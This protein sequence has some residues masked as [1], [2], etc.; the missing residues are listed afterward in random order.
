[1][2]KIVLPV[3]IVLSACAAVIPEPDPLPPAEN[4]TCNA[5]TYANLIGQDDEALER[6]LLMGLVRVIRP[7]MA[8]SM[9]YR[10]NRINFAIGASGRIDRIY[11]G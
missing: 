4:D 3:F 11:C 5:A 9:D 6:V 8:V 7:G 2:K 1:M 10:P